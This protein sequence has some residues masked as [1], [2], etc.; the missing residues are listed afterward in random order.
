MNQPTYTIPVG[1]HAGFGKRAWH[2]MP[3]Q[4][5]GCFALFVFEAFSIPTSSRLYT[6]RGACR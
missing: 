3:K 1:V 2:Q 4:P 5:L 6:V